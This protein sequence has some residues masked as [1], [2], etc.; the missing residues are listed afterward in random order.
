MIQV[1]IR[2]WRKGKLPTT[3]LV[4]TFNSGVLSASDINGDAFLLPRAYRKASRLKG[5]G[6]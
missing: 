5:L 1:I 2:R 4:R 3:H 6:G